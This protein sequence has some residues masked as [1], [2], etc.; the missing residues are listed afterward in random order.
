MTSSNF[1]GVVEHADYLARLNNGLVGSL[2]KELRET[3]GFTQKQ[4]SGASGVSA[5]TI[6]EIESG[7][8]IFPT[9]LTLSR[10][11]RA[12]GSDAWQDRWANPVA[13]YRIAAGLSRSGMAAR[14][15]VS[16][17]AIINIEHGHCHLST[18]MKVSAVMG[19]KHKTLLKAIRKK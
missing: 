18:V 10:L 7:K 2:L 5:S 8:Q 14:C 17:Q 15:G 6:S 1:S 9:A 16:R 12:L 3:R 13:Q 4:L 11:S 19:I